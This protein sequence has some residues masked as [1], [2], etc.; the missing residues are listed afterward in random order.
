MYKQ[1]CL[2]GQAVLDSNTHGTLPLILALTPKNVS[3]HSRLEVILQLRLT[4][5]E[6]ALL[7]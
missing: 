4:Q 1:D 5:L 6:L 7:V 3:A 2:P